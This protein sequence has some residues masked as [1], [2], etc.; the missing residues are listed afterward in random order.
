MTGDWWIRMR[1]L[2]NAGPRSP[3]LL[4]AGRAGLACYWLALATATH[5]PQLRFVNDKPFA[6]RSDLFIHFGAFALLTLGLWWVRPLGRVPRRKQA[7]FAVAVAG[8]YAVVDEYTQGWVGRVVALDDILTSLA[9]VAAAGAAL[10]WSSSGAAGR[11]EAGATTPA[12]AEVQGGA[13]AH[14]GSGGGGGFVRHAIVVSVLTFISRLTGLVRDAV[15]ASAFGL[16]SIADAFF[17]GFLVP[18]LFRRLFGEGALTAAFIPHYTDLLRQD[19]TL[20]RRF[21]SLWIAVLMI[22]LSAVTLVGEAVLWHASTLQW[23]EHTALAIRYTMIMLPYM[24]LVCLVALIG[25]VLQVHGRFG[26]A[27]A[28][29]VLLNVVMIAAAVAGGAMAFPASDPQAIMR[30]T[31]WLV[32]V[33]VLIAG[34]VQLV[35]QLVALVR[36][37]PLTVTFAGTGPAFRATMVMLL[38]MLMGLAVF[39][40][41]SFLDSVIAFALA[42]REG[43]PDT[44]TLLGRTLS[45]PMNEGAVAAL[46]WAQRLYQ[47]PLGVFGIAVATAIF[48]ALAH[49]THDA[50]RFRA[51]LQQGLRLTLFIGLPASVGLILVRV[52]LSR[53][54]YERG[55]FTLDDAARVGTIL[56][57]YSAAVWAYS[58]T[59]VLTRAFHA[60]KDARTPLRVSVAMVGL[61]FVLNMT[62]IWRLG[63]AGLAWATAIS[64]S[65]QVVLMLRA[66]QRYV[67]QPVDRAVVTSWLRTAAVTLLMA[68]AIAPAT[69]LYDPVALSR[70]GAAL[71][72]TVMVVA[73]GGVYAVASWLAGAP[74]LG[75]LRRRRPRG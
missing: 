57:G 41:N 38:P 26:P 18:N 28:A 45:Y 16:S 74:E 12:L 66:V 59:H 63:A 3:G 22:G 19:K 55:E 51:T 49:A 39:Q 15:L 5:M 47:F 71:Q 25:G 29:P 61:N 30:G 2:V 52:P 56:A 53:V 6:L 1:G 65:V 73:G 69:W 42:A 8:V 54:I 75:L 43:G 58:M 36:I 70:T 62:L 27:A 13:Q 10:V 67:D 11:G 40:I 34:A 9:G 64:S 21:A 44:F 37:Q 68:A 50:A 24:P 31:A 46:Q 7:W 32:S 14:G 72:L 48:P 60:R 17:I 33:S 20:A 35:W 23:T 4:A